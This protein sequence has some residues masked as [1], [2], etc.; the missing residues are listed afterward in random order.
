MSLTAKIGVVV[1][2]WLAIGLIQTF[3]W[4]LGIEKAIVM[5]GLV[6]AAPFV[7]AASR[8]APEPLPPRWE[9]AAGVATIVILVAE[10]ATAG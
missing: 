2:F 6:V 9:R 5:L 3:N 10:T 4:G 8:A 1:A 7:L